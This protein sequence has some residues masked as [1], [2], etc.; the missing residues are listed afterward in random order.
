MT[1]R[2]AISRTRLAALLLPPLLAMGVIFLLSA[3]PSDHVDRAWWDILLRKLAHVTEYAALTALW[4]RALCGLG[5]R[6]RLSLALA[7]AISLGYAATDEFHQTFVD[8]RTGTP[9]DVL[10]DSIGMALAATAITIRRLRAA[11]DAR[12]FAADGRV[13]ERL[14]RA[15]QPG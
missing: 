14:D 2:P 11:P 5:M 6:F 4:W 13:G 3:Q 8:G 9:V 1:S 12:A 7:I 15:R 10:I